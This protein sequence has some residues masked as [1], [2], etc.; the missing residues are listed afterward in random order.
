IKLRAGKIPAPA[1][2]PRSVA[3]DEL[4]LRPAIRWDSGF[5]SVWTP[6]EAG[7]Q[8]RLRK[9]IASAVDDYDEKRNRPDLDGT[10]ALSPHLHFGEIGPRQTWAAVRVPTKDS[11]I[12]PPSRGAQVFLGEV[13]WREFAHQLLF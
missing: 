7:A 3:L 9:F 4:A 13:G 12:F 6:G 10:S 11:G 1:K 2:W 8:R 5:G